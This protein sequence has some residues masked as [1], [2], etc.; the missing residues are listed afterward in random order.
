[1]RI[2]KAK[3][4][5]MGAV[6]ELIQELAT[7]QNKLS[8]VNIKVDD[9]IRDG[10][11]ESPQF[12][13]LVAVEGHEIIGIAFY[14]YGYST[15]V[16]KSIQLDDL[17]V[18]ENQRGKGIGFKLY[19]ELMKIAQIEQVQKVTWLVYHWNTNAIGFYKKCGAKALDDL[20]IMQ[21]ENKDDNL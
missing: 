7:F 14:S 8:A 6:F 4:E 11:T 12:H 21:V 1:M 10:F 19:D 16:G 18:K 17:I 15:W 5:D 3:K 20:L 2:R 13:C 9:L